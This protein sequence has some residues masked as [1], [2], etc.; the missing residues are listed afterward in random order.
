[1]NMVPARLVVGHVLHRRS[2]PHTHAFR[3]PLFMVRV[4]VDHLPASNWVLGL[5]RWGV[6]G[7]H[8][9]DHGDGRGP[10]ADWARAQLRAH[11]DL[12]P[13][14]DLNHTRIELITLPRMFGYTF[15][16]VSFWL[17]RDQAGECRAM[18]AEVNNTF[19]QRHTYVLPLWRSSQGWRAE[20]SKTFHVSPFYQVTGHYQFLL[21]ETAQGLSIHINY[22]DAQGHML[23]TRFGGQD[24]ALNLASVARCLGFMPWQSLMIWWRI[25]W[26]AWC[27]WRKGVPF[28]GKN[29]RV[30]AAPSPE[31]EVKEIAS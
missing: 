1:M 30:P 4:D 11:Q 6:L 25:H 21:A 31:F 14:L 9:Q 2:H 20:C 22:T 26:Q 23:H 19:G 3:Y 28:F 8:A 12:W 16:P 27:L 5:E 7:L 29:G 17:V 13:E 15:Q 18:L 10:L 24:Q